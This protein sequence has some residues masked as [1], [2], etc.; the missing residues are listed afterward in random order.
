MP[1]LAQGHPC[2]KP[3]PRSRTTP[4]EI[5]GEMI[6]RPDGEFEIR[7]R[8]DLA[9]EE[10]QRCLEDLS[11]QLGQLAGRDYAADFGAAH[12]IVVTVR[13][14]LGFV[15]R[16]MAGDMRSPDDPAN[17]VLSILEMVN[18]RLDV[19]AREDFYGTGYPKDPEFKNPAAQA[20]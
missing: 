6:R 5:A 16:S 18:E 11:R 4:P 7:W 20:A 13:E 1:R 12:H 15:I 14:A 10:R 19:I 9:P 2:V 8:A 17:G 3:A